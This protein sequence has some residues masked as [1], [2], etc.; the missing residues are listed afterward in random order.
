M[1]KK[2]VVKKKKKA[3]KAKT[4]DDDEEK[5]QIEIPPY[6]DPDLYAPRAKLRIELCAPISS[7]LGF[8]AE[9]MLTARVEEI[10]QLII[11]KFDGS[12]SD[13][14]MCLNSYEKCNI[15]DP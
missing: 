9:L 6:E 12:V 11:D 14:T 5:C 2:K 3:K 13:I 8:T 4:D 1:P 15:L 10:R 7:K